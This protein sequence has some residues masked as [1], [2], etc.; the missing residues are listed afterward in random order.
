MDW[1]PGLCNPV[2]GASKGGD[3]GILRPALNCWT[4]VGVGKGPLGTAMDWPV[5]A[6]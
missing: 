6:G 2:H 1:T 4:S 3:L 5:E